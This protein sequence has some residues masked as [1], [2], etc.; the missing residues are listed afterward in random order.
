MSS[1][2]ENKARS[3]VFFCANP[4]ILSAPCRILITWMILQTAKYFSKRISRRF[5]CSA[6]WQW[7]AGMILAT[8]VE[9]AADAITQI[10]ILQIQS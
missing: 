6:R 2:L 1:Q 8:L 9:A 4:L 10:K 3:S 7:N 5:H